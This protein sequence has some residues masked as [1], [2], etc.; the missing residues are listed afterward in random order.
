M[1]LVT[2]EEQTEEKFKDQ[3]GGVDLTA[4]K[5]IVSVGRGIGKEENLHLVKELSELLGAELG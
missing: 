1:S 4:A 3:Q 5:I 2:K